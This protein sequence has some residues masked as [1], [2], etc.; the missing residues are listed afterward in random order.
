[1]TMGTLRRKGEELDQQLEACRFAEERLLQLAGDETR[2]TG[3]LAATSSASRSWGEGLASALGAKVRQEAVE[4]VAD[5]APWQAARMADEAHREALQL[6]MSQQQAEAEAEVRAQAEAESRARKEAED[7]ERLA[8]GAKEA[9]RTALRAQGLNSRRLPLRPGL[10]PCGFFMRKGTCKKGKSCVWDHPEP[11]TNSRGYPQRPGQPSCAL[12][13]RTQTCKFGA[14][15]MYDHP[16]PQADAQDQPGMLPLALAKVSA[17]QHQLQLLLHL[18]LLQEL[19][20][21]QDPEAM[22]NAW[23]RFRITFALSG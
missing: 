18:Q 4:E 17:Q 16:E 21:Q 12:Y 13:G 2:G 10:P 7:A 3:T 11:D 14:L 1:M 5:E 23:V 6:L 8:E 22:M 15:C 20:G 19:P 9:E